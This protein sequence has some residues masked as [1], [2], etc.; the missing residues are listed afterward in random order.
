MIGDFFTKPLQGSQFRK[1]CA[2]ILNEP[3]MQECVGTTESPGVGKEGNDD[4]V[5]ATEKTMT[6]GTANAGEAAGGRRSYLD[7]VKSDQSRCKQESIAM[8]TC[9]QRKPY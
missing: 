4:P 2:F 3:S 5:P 1:L 7:V 9:L 6:N 8:L